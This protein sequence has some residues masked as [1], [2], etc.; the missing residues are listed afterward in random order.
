MENLQFKL[1]APAVTMEPEE[2]FRTDGILDAE[3]KHSYN[4][5]EEKS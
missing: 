2:I 5:V 1:A 4:S 3:P